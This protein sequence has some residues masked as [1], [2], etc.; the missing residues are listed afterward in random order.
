ME[1]EKKKLLIVSCTMLLAFLQIVGGHAFIDGL[2]LQR[3]SKSI[4]QIEAGTVLL[5]RRE[6]G[7]DGTRTL[8]EAGNRTRTPMEVKYECHSS[9]GRRKL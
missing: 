8:F 6:A 3:W 4:Q 1:H 7:L 5:T 2:V 9:I